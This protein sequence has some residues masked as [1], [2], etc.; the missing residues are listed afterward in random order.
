MET[1]DW[2]I[3]SEVSDEPPVLL[4]AVLQILLL[5]GSLTPAVIH[6]Y[7]WLSYVRTVPLGTDSDSEF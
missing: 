2:G 6:G 7:T 3:S 1:N 5:S 4:R